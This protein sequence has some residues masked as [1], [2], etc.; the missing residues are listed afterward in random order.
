MSPSPSRESKDGRE[1]G[2][3]QSSVLAFL[4]LGFELLHLRPRSGSRSCDVQRFQ[5]A[6]VALCVRYFWRVTGF[7]LPSNSARQFCLLVAV[8]RGCGGLGLRVPA[9]PGVVVAVMA[10]VVV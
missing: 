7:G 5:T 1:S 2:R 8:F 3:G 4:W 9:A 6:I 10:V